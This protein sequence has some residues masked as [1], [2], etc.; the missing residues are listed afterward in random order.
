[1]TAVTSETVDSVGYDPVA[2]ERGGV[3]GY[4]G[5]SCELF[6]QMLRPNAWVLRREQSAAQSIPAY[7]T[8][9]E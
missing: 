8:A 5:A 3:Y 9:F 7:G 2:V 1:M 6:Q 4:G